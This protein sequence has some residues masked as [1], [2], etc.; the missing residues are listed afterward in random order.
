MERVTV[1]LLEP[2]ADILPLQR[3]EFAPPQPSANGQ[4]HQRS[5]SWL[6]PAQELLDVLNCQDC[7]NLSTLRTLSNQFDR[8]AIEQIVPAGVIEECLHNTPQ[9]RAGCG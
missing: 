2:E 7:W 4:Q 5:F 6:Q 9:L 8:I 1:N 3:E